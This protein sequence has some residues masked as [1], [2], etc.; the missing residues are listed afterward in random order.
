M[1][2]QIIDY[3]PRY[4]R[5]FADM[6][7]EWISHYFAVEPHDLEQLE[8]P[9]NYILA[10]G[11]KIF[12]ARYVDEIIGTV[13][14]IKES[15]TVYEMAKMAVKPEFRGLSAGEKLGRHLIEAAKKLGCTRL[16]LESNQKLIPALTLYK[17][18]GFVE[19]PIGETLYSR[20]N[21]KAEIYFD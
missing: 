18:L 10:K 19:V 14:L 4:R 15:E 5:E 12:F 3:E 1:E 21:Y 2:V 7:I 17:K 9:E 11:G 6:N 20:A 16:F 8:N 13:A